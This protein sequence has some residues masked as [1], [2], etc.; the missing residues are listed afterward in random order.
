MPLANRSGAT[1]LV[2]ATAVLLSTRLDSQIL[3][4][5]GVGEPLDVIRACL[6]D[7]RTHA[8]EE[9][10]LEDRH[11]EHPVVH[12]LLDL[13]QHRLALL[14][15]ELA[16]L[17][18]EEVL[19]LRHDPRRVDSGL[20]HVDLDAR[21][22]VAGGDRKST[23]L[24]SS[25]PSISYAVFCLKKKKKQGETRFPQLYKH[26]TSK[27][28]FAAGFIIN[29]SPLRHTLHLPSRSFFFFFNDTA[30]TEIYTL[31]LHDALPIYGGAYVPETLV[32]ALDELTAAAA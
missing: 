21:R 2:L 18:L 3:V 15:V 17:A 26:I 9:R 5:R 31:S 25:H 12:D 27:L 20:Q 4:G 16:R 19:D 22:R 6:L 30:T 14:P 28:T 8:P 1:T 10:E 11:V 7:P 29:D 23:C 13:V 32:P 24:N